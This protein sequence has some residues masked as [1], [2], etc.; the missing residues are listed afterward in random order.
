MRSSRDMVTF[1]H[2]FKL[3]A[4]DTEQ[5]AGTYMVLTEEEEIPGLSFLAWRRVATQIHLPA[6]GRETGQEQVVTIDPKELADARTRDTAK[7]ES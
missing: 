6:I 2:P 3:P 1:H 5:P 4:L 7:L